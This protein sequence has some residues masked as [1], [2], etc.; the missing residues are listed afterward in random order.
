MTFD[1]FV[2]DDAA[3]DIDELFAHSHS[4]I[5][6]AF[7]E[8]AESPGSGLHPPELWTLGIREYRELR[9]R[10]YRIIYRI[11]GEEVQVLLICDEKRAMQSLLQRRLLE[12]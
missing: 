9:L 2:T 3:R 1:V 5:E 12:S 7:G 4:R 11:R 10:P 6:S 8:L